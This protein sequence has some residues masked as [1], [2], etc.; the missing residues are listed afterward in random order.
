MMRRII[1]DI[2]FILAAL[3]AMP[4][5]TNANLTSKNHALVDRTR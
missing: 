3:V 4:A 1:G 2:A 5:L